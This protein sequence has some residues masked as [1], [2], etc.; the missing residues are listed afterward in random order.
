MCYHDILKLDLSFPAIPDEFV[1]FGKWPLL[2]NA[3]WLL[4]WKEDT[5]PTDFLDSSFPFSPGGFLLCFLLCFSPSL[6]RI[7]DY[8]VRYKLNGDDLSSEHLAALFP[9]YF[10]CVKA[11][12]KCMKGKIWKYWLLGLV[13]FTAES[14]NEMC[15]TSCPGATFSTLRTH[16]LSVSATPPSTPCSLSSLWCWTKML[17][18][19]L[20]CYTQS[21]TKIFWRYLTVVLILNDP[22]QTNVINKTHGKC[23]VCFCSQGRPLSFKTFLIW[24]LISIYQGK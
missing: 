12:L 3:A 22:V 9:W 5:F 6:P 4:L 14:N 10:L 19:R 7:L 16:E 13:H 2:F 17:S 18:Q 15:E 21:Y 1:V 11:L 24:V 23:N 8:W 20:P